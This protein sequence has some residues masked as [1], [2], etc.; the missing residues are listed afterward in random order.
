VTGSITPR[1]GLQKFET[2]PDWGAK[3]FRHLRAVDPLR[4]SLPECG[5]FCGNAVSHQD[6]VVCLD[7]QR[8]RPC[9]A[10]KISDLRGILNNSPADWD[11][12]R[13]KEYFA[14]AARVVAGFTS[15]NPA[16]KAEFDK[17]ILRAGWGLPSKS[18]GKPRN[19]STRRSK[20]P[21]K[22]AFKDLPF[23]ERARE[24][25]KMMLKNLKDNAGKD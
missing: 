15:P 24:Y 8:A 22:R 14:W 10:D 16:L 2:C 23:K 9:A 1:V 17:T 19:P 20:A 4:P 18:M 3:H 11:L 7:V 25:P 21:R 12:D 6:D 13:Q 5:D